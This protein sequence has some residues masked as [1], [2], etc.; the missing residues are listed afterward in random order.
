MD[1]VELHVDVQLRES[2]NAT[3]TSSTN[4]IGDED[5][6]PGLESTHPCVMCG[7]FAERDRHAGRKRLISREE[8]R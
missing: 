8:S 6:L 1:F 4:A 3:D 7:L 2:H 5:R